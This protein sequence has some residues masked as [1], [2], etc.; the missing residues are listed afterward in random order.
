MS[1]SPNDPD[2]LVCVA[3][4]TEFDHPADKPLD[5]CVICDVRKTI[6][7]R[8]RVPRL[9]TRSTG[10]PPIRPPHRPNLDLSVPPLPNPHQHLVPN[11]HLQSQLLLPHHHPQLWHRPTRNP[12]QNPPRKRPLGLPHAPR[13]RDNL[14]DKFPRRAESHCNLTPALLHLAPSL[15]GNVQLSGVHF[16]A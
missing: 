3:C 14:L 16:L 13:R 8:N 5:N 15:G 1:S 12:H 9:T 11:R 10:P 2:L 4:G 7:P 6:H